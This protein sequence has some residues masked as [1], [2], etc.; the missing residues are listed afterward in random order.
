MGS[1]SSVLGPS[2]ASIDSHP[3]RVRLPDEPLMLVDRIVSSRAKSGRS[4]ADGS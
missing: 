4:R 2:Y 1:I 3:T